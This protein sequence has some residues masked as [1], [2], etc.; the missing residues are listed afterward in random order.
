MKAVIFDRDGVILDSESTNIESAVKAFSELG[1]KIKDEEKKWII[2]RHP[3]DYKEDFLKHYN[4][5]YQEFLKL[6]KRIY[7]EILESTP[8][9][10]KTISLIKDLNKLGI[11]LALTTSSGP[12]STAKV[13]KKAGLENTFKIVI[14]NN[15]YEK[16]KPDPEPY[17]VT[18]KKLN[19]SPEDCVVIEDSQLGVESAKSAGMKVIAIPNEYTKDQDFS[20]ADKIVS[21]AGEITLELLNKL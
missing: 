8:F 15:Y 17:E 2:A 4:F 19:L 7:H 14:T 10:E 11:T 20:K 16:R 5:D 13:L 21:S 12:D 3:M 6:Q 18:A 9:F 1:I